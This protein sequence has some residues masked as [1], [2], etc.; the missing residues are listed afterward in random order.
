MADGRIVGAAASQPAICPCSVQIQMISEL[1]KYL[2]TTHIS[3]FIH[4][5]VDMI[6]VDVFDIW[7]HILVRIH[8]DIVWI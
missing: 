6:Y 8:T 4:L 3:T 5:D 2:Y 1:K 7:M